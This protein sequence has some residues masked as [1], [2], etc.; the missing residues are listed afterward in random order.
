VL[1]CYLAALVIR[2]NG[3]SEEM[4]QMARQESMAV[5]NGMSE[6]EHP[7]QAIADLITIQEHFGTLTDLH[8]LYVGEGNNSAAALALAVGKLEGMRLTLATPQG[9]GLREDILRDAAAS[10][11]RNHS[12]IEQFHDI[13]DLGSP[14][15]IVYTTRWQTMGVPHTESTWRSRFEPF[16]VDLQLMNRVSKGDRTIFMHDLPAMRGEEVVAEVLDGPQSVAL[17]QASHK[18]T[19][20]LAVLDFCARAH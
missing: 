13:R 10:A 8:I 14:V 3:P 17:R 19:G 18:L 15:D 5:I 20:A 1:S 11:L 7:T 9:Y 12:I 4:S 16:R 2:T 6:S